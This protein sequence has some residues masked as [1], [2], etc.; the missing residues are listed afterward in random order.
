M[1]QGRFIQTIEDRC[2]VCY[3]CARECP[4]KAIRIS[5]GRAE[6]LPERCICCGNCV[7]VCSQG[8]KQIVRTIDLATQL[9]DSDGPVAAC[10]AP[11]FPAEFSDIAPSCLAAMIRKLGFD[12]VAEVG[13]GADLVANRYRRLLTQAAGKS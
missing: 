5:E 2:R 9:L 3:T 6:I 10:I 7:K 13:F 4:A 8:A 11:S 1:E 12:M